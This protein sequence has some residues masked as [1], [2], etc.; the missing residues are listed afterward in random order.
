MSIHTIAFWVCALFLIGVFFASAV[1]QLPIIIPLILIVSLYFIVFKKYYFA[2]LAFFIIA[3]AVYYQ[4]FDAIRREA[5]VPFGGRTEF[6]ALIKKASQ[7]SANQEIIAELISPYSGKIRIN[8]ARY[9]SFEYGDLVEVIGAI[10]KP[11]EK[12]ADYFLKEGIAGIINLPKIEL[13][14][15]GQGNYIK[16]RLLKFK[17]GII[18][19]FKRN[20]PPEKAAFLSGITLG[21]RQEFSKEFEEKMSLSGTTH[22]VALS[23][24]NIS[25]IVLAAGTLFSFFFSRLISFYLSVGFIILFVLMTGV[26]ASIIRAAIMGVIVLLAEETERIYSIRNAIIIS[27]FLMVLFNPRVLAFD[28]GFQL[29]FAALLGIVYILPA[30]KNILKIKNK[31]FL[32]W[33]ENALTTVSAQLAVAPLLLGNFGIFSLTSFLP[34]ILSAVPLTMGLGFLMGWLGFISE[35]LAQAVGLAVNLLLTYELWLID[36]FS[37]I[38]LPIITDSFGFLA[39]IIYYLILTCFIYKFN[40]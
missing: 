38:T 34:K 3:G 12:S 14:E 26:E 30:L 19:I 1:N 25:V 8:A 10:Q 24:Y 27:A 28:L 32:S 15:S 4:V 9:P 13:L 29:S 18:G 6:R 17:T 5:N 39:A 37:R 22:I 23:G 16:S 31:G 40:K 7:S 36:L 21:E 11:P 20:L 35:F 33:K 2:L